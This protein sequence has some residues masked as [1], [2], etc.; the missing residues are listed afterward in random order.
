MEEFLSNRISSKCSSLEEHFLGLIPHPS[1]VEGIPLH[2]Q[3]LRQ[4]T[5]GYLCQL[6]NNMRAVLE[7]LEALREDTENSVNGLH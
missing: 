4:E 5:K 6:D 1:I 7:D 2:L 3:D